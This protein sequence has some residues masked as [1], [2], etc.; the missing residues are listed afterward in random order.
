M[1]TYKEVVFSDLSASTYSNDLV[2]FW[3]IQDVMSCQLILQILAQSLTL[4][5]RG[6]SVSFS[7]FPTPFSHGYFFLAAL[8]VLGIHALVLFVR[9]F[10]RCQLNCSSSYT[11]LSW[12]VWVVMFGFPLVSLIVGFVYNSYDAKFFKRYLQF[13][14]LEF[15]TRLGMHSPR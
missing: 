6:Q 14:R 11:S 13:L 3:L 5:E 7:N 12:E 4:L 15:D 8:V 10:T 1:V 9:A 2:G